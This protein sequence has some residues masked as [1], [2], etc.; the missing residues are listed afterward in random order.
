MSGAAVKSINLECAFYGNSKE[1]G[2]LVTVPTMSPI[3]FSDAGADG[4]RRATKRRRVSAQSVSPSALDRL[5]DG[6]VPSD[7]SLEDDVIDVDRL[8][9]DST[10]EG[11]VTVASERAAIDTQVRRDLS[12]PTESIAQKDARYFTL[13]SV[14]CSL[15]GTKG[16][17]SYSCTEKDEERCFVCGVS[18]HR[19]R[20]CPQTSRRKQQARRVIRRVGAPREPNLRCYVCKERGHLDCSIG[21]WKGILSCCNCGVAGHAG[22]GCNMPSAERVLP[23]VRDMERERKEKARSAKQKAKGSQRISDGQ[24]KEEVKLREASEFHESLLNHLR[25]RR[26][27]RSKADHTR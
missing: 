7:G 23:I 9:D 26:Y 6:E 3:F 4:D 24:G 27:G 25:Q 11:E 2:K 18:G 19:G 1:L 22:A 8:G 10:E 16:H 15:C 12:D 14:I 17:M 21:Q 13:P 20:E 5:E